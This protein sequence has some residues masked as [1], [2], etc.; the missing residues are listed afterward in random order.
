MRFI[1][2]ALMAISKKD[3]KGYVALWGVAGVRNVGA[4]RKGIGYLDT[5]RSQGYITIDKKADLILLTEKGEREIDGC[6]SGQ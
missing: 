2:K 3:D 4:L 1:Q 6:R 5:L